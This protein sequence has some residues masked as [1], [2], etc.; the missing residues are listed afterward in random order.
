MVDPITASIPLF[1]VLIGVEL[2]VG[3]ATGRLRGP[4]PLYRWADALVDLGCGVSSQVTG[5]VLSTVVA[6]GAYVAVYGSCRL[7]SWPEGVGG[8]VIAFVLVD[9]LYYWWHRASHRVNLLWAAHVV[10]HQSEDY[11]LAVALRQAM[12]TALTSIPFYLPLAVIGVPPATFF[13]CSSLNT[14]YQFWIHTRLI[15]RLGPLEW[16]LNTPSHHRVHHGIN[17]RYIDKNHAGVFIVWDRLFGTF[18]PEDDEPVYGTVGGF[19][20]ANA[21]FANLEPLL[22][23]WAVARQAR[24]W[25][26]LFVLVRPPEWRPE[27][28]IQIPEP[29]G[30]LR[31]RPEASGGAVAWTA[32]W[33]VVSAAA[34]TWC[35]IYQHDRPLV[36]VAAAGVLIL[37]TVASWGGLFSTI[38][39][40]GRAWWWSEGARVVGVI[41]VA[42]WI[43]LGP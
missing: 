17:P 15:G 35:L 12:F 24:G 41:A 42:G 16:V 29:A 26:R 9:C 39:P 32:A 21:L 11:N 20:S 40:P 7:G 18:A 14:L 27:G 10:H 13:L 43:V 28:P 34:L 8:V 37:W 25:D 1:F 4:R 38:G 6:A 30:E 5:M 2:A 19:K 3:A 31:W 23:L 36:Q 22:S 33:L